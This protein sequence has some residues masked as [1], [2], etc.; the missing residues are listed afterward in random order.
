M[1]RRE[2]LR[3]ETAGQRPYR[4]IAAGSESASAQPSK[5]AMRVRF[6][7]P[8]PAAKPPQ[9]G[10]RNREERSDGSRHP[11][12]AKRT[13]GAWNRE[14]R[15]P[16]CRPPVPRRSRPKRHEA[17]HASDGS[18]HP[19]ARSTRTALGIGRSAAT[20]P[21]TRSR[22]AHIVRRPRR[23]LLQWRVQGHYRHTGL[24]TDGLGTRRRRPPARLTRRNTVRARGPGSHHRGGQFAVT[25]PDA[26]QP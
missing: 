6:P 26:S 13:H 5:L 12:C 20:D 23:R 14:E 16:S 7:S 2:V 15:A 21:V 3:H 25:V 11:L 1:K 24:A 19:L 17:A 9:A 8:A 4:C 10:A 18:R 22:E